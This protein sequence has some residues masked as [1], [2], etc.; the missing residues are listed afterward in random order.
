MRLETMIGALAAVILSA[1]P[2]FAQTPGSTDAFTLSSGTWW[3]IGIAAFLGFM[4]GSLRP[5]DPDAAVKWDMQGAL[6]MAM[7]AAAIVFGIAAYLASGAWVPG[8]YGL[9][10]GLFLC[11]MRFLMTRPAPRPTSRLL[12]EGVHRGEGDTAR[13]RY[14]AAERTYN[15][16]S[17]NS[18]S[19]SRYFASRGRDWRF[20]NGADQSFVD[21]MVDSARNASSDTFDILVLLVSDLPGEAG[22][23]AVLVVRG[24]QNLRK[25]TAANGN[26]NLP[27]YDKPI[28]ASSIRGLV[29]YA[30]R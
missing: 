11:A 3:V 1:A 6:M 17:F 14:K 9:G 29:G 5:N 13:A 30:W 27:C 2:A 19:N 25:I 4:L 16:A 20:K 15:R 10:F 7:A 18:G 21:M 26:L 28:P 22:V 23:P 8:I 24:G 12:D